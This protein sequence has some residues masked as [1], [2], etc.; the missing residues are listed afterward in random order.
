MF[1][2][3]HPV[4]V[5]FSDLDLLGHVNNARYLTYMEQGRVAYFRHLGLRRAGEL[6]F[7]F[8]LAH[9]AVD[10][11][12]PIR[13]DAQVRVGVRVARLGR[14]SFTM[15]YRLEQPESGVVYATGETVQVTYDYQQE[16][17]VPIPEAWRQIIARFEGI[18]PGP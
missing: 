17:T 13:L 9:A 2:F 16:Q 1:R 3:Y 5:R 15:A 10:F 18:P 6:T 11:L 7:G 8:I 4:T 12:R 14:K